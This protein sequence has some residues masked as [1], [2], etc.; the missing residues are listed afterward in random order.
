ML[1]RNRLIFLHVQDVSSSPLCMIIRHK[2]TTCTRKFRPNDSP[3]LRSQA[4]E[5]RFPRISCVTEPYLYDDILPNNTSA[6]P[7]PTRHTST[8]QTR[9]DTNIDDQKHP[10][11]GTRVCVVLGMVVGINKHC[12]NRSRRIINLSASLHPQEQCHS[13]H[14]PQA[15]SVAFSAS[16]SAL[17]SP[18]TE[19]ATVCAV[20]A[21]TWNQKT[22]AS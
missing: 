11:S 9:K 5:F 13:L 14:P 17:W 10:S 8:F 22:R 19:K 1:Y 12:H 7:R 21:S 20:S 3:S 6:G 18:S 4:A 16:V 15:Y 2:I